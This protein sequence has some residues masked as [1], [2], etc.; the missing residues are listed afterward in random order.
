MK[1]HPR[2]SWSD[3]ERERV[4]AYLKA[5][6][7]A[8]QIRRHFPELTRNA[9]IG[10][11]LR[12]KMLKTIGFNSIAKTGPGRGAPG[13]PRLLHLQHKKAARASDPGLPE[14]PKLPKPRFEPLGTELA[15]LGPAECRFPIAETETKRGQIYLFCGEPTGDRAEVYCERHKAVCLR[16]D[17]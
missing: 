14:P 7:T 11:V 15:E 8:T 12:D 17:G 9:V 13:Q 1:I 4:A 5:G 10:R 2:P 6:E 3:E 16:R